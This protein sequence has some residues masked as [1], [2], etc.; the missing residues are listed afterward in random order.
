VLPHLKKSAVTSSNIASQSQQALKKLE[1]HSHL[2]NKNTPYRSF[3]TS[4]C[5]L[6]AVNALANSFNLGR[7]L[8]IMLKLSP[9]MLCCTVQKL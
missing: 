3:T 2:A 7:D 6:V 4:L 1:A 8:P 9:V 5:F